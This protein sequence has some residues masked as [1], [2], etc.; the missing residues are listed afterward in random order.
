V[1]GEINVGNTLPQNSPA[2][3]T[4]SVTG[5]T[6]APAPQ[7][8]PF[9]QKMFSLYGQ[10]TGVPLA[11]LGCPFNS[12]GTP[13]SGATPSGNGCSNRQSISH[14]SDD[15]E[16]VQTARIDY[17]VNTNNTAW[18]RFQADTGVHD[19]DWLRSTDLCHFA[20]NWLAGGRTGW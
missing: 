5:S 6:Y 11:V 18:F 14:S 12:D 17:N 8:V 7:L 1:S 13:A 9:Y 4:D 2:G 10:T 15:H 16:Q 20:A 19:P 3:G